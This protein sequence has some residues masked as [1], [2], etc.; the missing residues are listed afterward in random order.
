MGETFIW[1]TKRGRGE[2]VREEG[3]QPTHWGNEFEVPGVSHGARNLTGDDATD[4]VRR[5][6][7]S[8]QFWRIFES[9]LK[10]PKNIVFFRL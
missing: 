3:K 9:Y 2:T 5:K 1:L 10:T 7:V 4:D 6:Y 8:H